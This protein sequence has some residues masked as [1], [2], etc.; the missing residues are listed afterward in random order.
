VIQIA[1]ETQGILKREIHVGTVKTPIPMMAVWHPGPVNGYDPVEKGLVEVG[2]KFIVLVHCVHRTIPNSDHWEFFI[3]VATE[4]G[5]DDCN[6]DSWSECEWSDVS[7]Y[8]E[9]TEENMPQLYWTD[10]GPSH[11]RKTQARHS[12][13]ADTCDEST[14]Q[15][16][17]EGNQDAACRVL[18]PRQRRVFPRI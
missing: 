3:I 16:A 9:L 17:G 8:L 10:W 15:R 14:H 2:D 1:V 11:A 12:E 7:W 13:E 6:G 5:W 4:T 18:A